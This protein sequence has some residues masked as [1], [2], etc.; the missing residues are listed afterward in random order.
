MSLKIHRVIEQSPKIRTLQG[1]DPWPAHSHDTR[2][3]PGTG[4]VESPS[5]EQEPHMTAQAWDKGK[6]WPRGHTV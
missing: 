2:T 6:V 3:S 4:A 5:E 1:M